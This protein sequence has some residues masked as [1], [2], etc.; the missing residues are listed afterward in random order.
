MLIEK[1][2]KELFEDPTGSEYLFLKEKYS[3]SHRFYHTLRHIED[4]LQKLQEISSIVENLKTLKLAIL[5]HDIFYDPKQKDN[6]DKSAA[7]ASRLLKN[8]V[9]H[10]NIADEVKHLILL[11]KHPSTPVSNDEKLL[12]DIDLSILGAA[13]EEYA[14][15]EKNIRKE[16][17]HVPKEM[18][19][20]GRSKLLWK[21]LKK[22]YVFQTE[23]FRSRYESQARKNLSSALRNLQ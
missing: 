19:S 10:K 23:Y 9:K 13:T 14:I 4:C 5:Y 8:S 15:Y 11:T 17:I 6:E 1:T 2:Y 22:D 3:E 7:Y 12:L 16:Y 21:F 18:Y 20:L